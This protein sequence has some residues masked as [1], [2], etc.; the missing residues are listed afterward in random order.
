ML[1]RKK[2]YKA[3]SA[4]NELIYKSLT[5]EIQTHLIFLVDASVVS[6]SNSYITSS[7]RIRKLA[8]P[9]HPPTW[10]G[11][12]ST[13]SAFYKV[14]NFPTYELCKSPTSGLPA[15]LIQ[16]WDSAS[17]FVAGGQET[18]KDGQQRGVSDIP[19]PFSSALVSARSWKL[20][21]LISC[22]AVMSLCFM[23]TCTDAME[24][25]RKTK[26]RT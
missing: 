19:F 7:Y 1:N 20:H 17:G 2:L 8:C 22:T 25:C 21:C 12:G 4:Q 6:F 15:E 16:M 9:R 18:H 10:R 13:P 3:L 24:I 23:Q 26:N 14:K 5:S 11:D